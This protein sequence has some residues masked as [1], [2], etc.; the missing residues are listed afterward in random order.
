MEEVVVVGEGDVRACVAEV[1]TQV[2]TT[3]VI[4]GLCL[5]FDMIKVLSIVGC[6]KAISIS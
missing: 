4:Y 6:L 3:F 1:T 2:G 5:V